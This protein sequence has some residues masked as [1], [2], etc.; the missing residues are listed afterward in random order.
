MNAE[1]EVVGCDKLAVRQLHKR[2]L[3]WGKLDRHLEVI[4]LL[5]NECFVHRRVY[6]PLFNI[7][8]KLSEA[9]VGATLIVNMVP[10]CWAVRL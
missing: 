3:D 5:A 1:E 6:E 8:R 2:V 4:F 9:Q 10:C 7:K